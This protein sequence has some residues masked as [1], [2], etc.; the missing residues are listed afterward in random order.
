MCHIRLWLGGVASASPKR[1]HIRPLLLPPQLLEG[2]SPGLGWKVFRDFPEQFASPDAIE[3]W[4]LLAAYLFT[5]GIEPEQVGGW[6]GSRQPCVGGGGFEA[7]A[8]PFVRHVRAQPPK[9]DRHLA[10]APSLPAHLQITSMFTRHHVLFR[11]A[12]A[13]PDALRRLFTW[14]QHDLDLPPASI[15]RLLRRCPTV[16]QVRRGMGMQGVD[17]GLDGMG[18]GLNQHS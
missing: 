13:R 16:L 7:G 1:A 10:T 6:R 2:L 15:I 12:V 14:L 17:I 5:L 8:T 4:R 11:H 3:C 18:T 9:T